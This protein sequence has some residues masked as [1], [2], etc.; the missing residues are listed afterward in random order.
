MKV[1][2]ILK[3][4]GIIIIVLIVLF[5]IHSFRNFII[6]SKIQDRVAKYQNSSNYH[7]H[8]VSYQDNITIIS[9]YYTKDNKEFMTLERKSENDNTKLS[10]YNNGERIDMFVENAEEKSVQ[11][12]AVKEIMPIAVVNVLQTDNKW[13]TFLYGSISKIK[14]IEYEGK[15]CYAIDN[16]VSPYHLHTPDEKPKYII[17]KE[18]GLLLANKSNNNIVAE[19]EY[20]FDNVQDSVFIEPDI[21]QYKL[22]E[23]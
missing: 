2:K 11:I 10:F 19:R 17:E 5:L 18:T 22:L 9:D 21:S 16:Y 12:N 15:Q 20:E 1:K 8:S 23:N 6:I 7:V 3:I 14:T 4:I 13:Q